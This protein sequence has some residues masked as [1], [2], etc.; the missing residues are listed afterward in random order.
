MAP[1]QEAERC[2]PEEEDG[3]TDGLFA[4]ALAELG[5]PQRAVLVGEL[6]ERTPSRELL[7]HFCR[8]IFGETLRDPEEPCAHPSVGPV[9]AR[10][11]SRAAPERRLRSPLIFVLF[12]LSSVQSTTERRGL[13]EILRDVR[14]RNRGRG[15]AVVGVIVL[16]PVTA[17]TL[18]APAEESA[19]NSSAA[20]MGAHDCSAPVGAPGASP[21]H[22]M[23]TERYLLAL[24]SSVFLP[25]G[26]PVPSEESPLH[27]AL[28]RPGDQRTVLGVKRVACR[29]LRATDIGSDAVSEGKQTNSTFLKC[30]PWKRRSGSLK[31]A[32]KPVSGE[33]PQHPEEGIAL[34]SLCEISNGGC[35]ENH[36]DT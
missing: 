7:Q 20:P 33:F 19:S 24:L 2:H 25:A 13:R 5:G 22:F 23:D 15:A 34:K 1:A 8:D 14:K 27:T 3:D 32:G 36:I 26:P 12:R 16:P 28:Y 10:A 9:E 35:E 11:P 29:A 17:E 31:K 18:G 21:S 30:F 4:A 6:W